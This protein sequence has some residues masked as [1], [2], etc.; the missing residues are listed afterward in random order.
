MF[1]AGVTDAFQATDEQLDAA[2]A[3]LVELGDLM[4]IRYTIDGSYAG[5]P[6]GRFGLH[7]A[8]AG[9]MVGSLQ[10]FPEG[11]DTTVVRYLWPGNSPKSTVNGIISNDVMTV[12]RGA[13]SPVLAHMFLDWLLEEQ[14]AIHN[15]TWL[16]YQPPQVGIDPETLVA[17]QLVPEYLTSAVIRESDFTA[18]RGTIPI[19]LEPQRRSAWDAAWSRVQSGG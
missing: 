18:P 13:Q 17:D 10:Y 4:N 11:A 1:R 12:L 6:E 8:W 3:S 15:F 5:I 19:E 14:N 16:G 2:V 9:D 7:H